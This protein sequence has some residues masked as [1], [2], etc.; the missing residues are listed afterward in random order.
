MEWTPLC[1]FILISGDPEFFFREGTL[2]VKM[3]EMIFDSEP[4]QPELYC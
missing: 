1:I 2:D 3:I 4:C